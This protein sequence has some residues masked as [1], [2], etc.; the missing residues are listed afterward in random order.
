MARDYDEKRDF[1]RMCM[2]CPMTF[3]RTGDATV[4]SAK[5]KDLSSSGLCM[6]T[7]QAV[8]VGEVLRVHL[9]PPMAVVPPLQA[10][11]EVVRVDGVGTDGYEVGLSIKG[12]S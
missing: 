12:F 9:A 4:Y 6:T 7:E 11:V 5:A 2:D 1:I 10:D 3:T 8:Q